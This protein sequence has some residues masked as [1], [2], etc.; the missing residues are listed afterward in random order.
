MAMFSSKKPDSKPDSTWD[1]KP[2]ADVGATVKEAPLVTAARIYGIQ[3]AIQLMR[4]LPVEQNAELV[5]RVVRATLGSLNVKLPDIIDDAAR[6]QK[7]TQDKINEKHTQISD[8]EKQLEGHR[9][10]IAA[11]EA[12]LKETTAVKERLQQAERLASVAA[13]GPA[14]TTTMLG[15]PPAAHAGKPD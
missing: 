7:Q 15:N 5:V 12:D 4:G 14:M 13:G 1:P 3:E 10:E 8:L 9:K 11:L 2:Q 6:K